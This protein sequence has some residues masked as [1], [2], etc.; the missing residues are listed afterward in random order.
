MK[1]M[2]SKSRVAK[3]I[4]PIILKQR[5][6]E[7]FYVE[8]F[9]GGMNIIDKV[10]GNRIANDVNPYLIAC[11]N[12]LQDGWLPPKFISREQY[13]I[14]RV[15][16]NSKLQL[17]PDEQ[18]EVGYIGF[19]GSYGGRFF[20][21]GYAGLTKTKLGKERNYPLEAF[22]NVM[23]QIE[24]IQ[25]VKFTCSSYD[26]MKTPPNSIIYCDPPYKDTKEYAKSGFD[27]DKFWQ[28]CRDKFKEGHSVFVSEYQAPN[29]FSCV[30]E[31]EVSSSLR[32]NSVVS[33]R[34]LSVERLFTFTGA[35]NENPKM[36]T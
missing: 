9:A 19:S 31:K 3:H 17:S 5:K 23:A 20:E 27:S 16:Y 28:W 30:W 36:R 34:K 25:G 21:G 22:N 1:Y 29:D 2:G 26:D 4:L 15:K 18:G 8:P 13:N 24:A 14:A 33:G 6:R 12:L 11:W 7:Q 32:A 35:S 10:D